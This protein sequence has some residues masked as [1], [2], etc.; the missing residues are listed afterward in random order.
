MGAHPEFA[1]IDEFQK[2]IVILLD[3]RWSSVNG[4]GVELF[5]ELVPH[6]GHVK[7]SFYDK[8]LQ[9]RVDKVG[10]WL[11]RLEAVMRA[12]RKLSMRHDIS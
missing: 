2:D 3:D 12:I 11:D 6:L 1:A 4:I 9:L 7:V 10:N 5:N 8:H